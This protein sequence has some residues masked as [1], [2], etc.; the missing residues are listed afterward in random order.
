[1]R[2]FTRLVIVGIVAILALIP[3]GVFV[4]GSGTALGADGGKNWKAKWEKVVKEAK[5][6]G[7]APDN[8]R[9]KGMHYSIT[10]R[11]EFMDL[12]PA[13]KVIRDA[14]RKAGRK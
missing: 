2:L 14:L 10:E 9:K 4:P 11:A 3:K 1:M 5:K 12:K 13:L 6:N 7:V 8:L